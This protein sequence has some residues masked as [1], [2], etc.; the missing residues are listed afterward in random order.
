MSTLRRITPALILLILSPLI[1]EFLLG[2]FNIR[3]LGYLAIFIPLYGASALF[4]REITRRMKRGWPT[5]LLLALVYAFVAEGFVNQ[6]LFNQNYAGQHLLAYGFIP[7]LG[8]SLN[9]TIYILSLHVIWSISTPIALAEGIAGSRSKEPWLRNWELVFVGVLS[10]LGLAGTT[11]STIERFHFVASI[12]QYISVSVAILILIFLA[13]KIFRASNDTETDI[14]NDE[15][16]ISKAPS[17]WII[18]IVSFILTTAFQVWFHYAP[19]HK[20]NALLGVIVFL[21]L[22]I[23][24]LMLFINWSRRV[25]WKTQHIVAAATGAV[26]TYGW[27]G[28]RRLL[29]SGHTALGVPTTTIDLVG[30]VMLLLAILG[31]SYLALRRLRN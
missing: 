24:A 30:Q 21:A 26:A 17:I 9:Y 1:A 12:A 2:D 7:F 8:T 22:D 14:K 20:L 3:Q 15:Q 13:F 28:L 27:F 16:L 29:V 11:A 4:I 6:T 10:L 31:M 23:L 19:G 5:M 25:D 18:F